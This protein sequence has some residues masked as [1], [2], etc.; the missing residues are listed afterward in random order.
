MDLT[1]LPQGKQPIGC[2]WVYKIKYNAKGD[3]ER[4]K[5]RLF[6]KGY[7]QLEGI[8]Y[9]DTFSPV[10]K[11]T[12]V[13]M[14]LVIAATQNWH[15]KQLDV[16]NAF[17]HGELNEEVYMLPPPGIK[18]KTGQV[19]KLVK[20]LYGLKQASRQ[21]FAKLTSSLHKIGFTQ[22]VYDHSLFIKNSENSFTVLLVYVDDII[23]AGKS[24]VDIE[25]VT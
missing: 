20:S 14:L 21:W 3:I 4:H 22:S 10:V 18:V 23:L 13:R 19:C 5:A 6:A 25:Q 24:I 8:N 17:L 1:N 9:L 15:L 11:L 2:K 7:T 12:T 16:N